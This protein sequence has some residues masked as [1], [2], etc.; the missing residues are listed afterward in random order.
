MTKKHSK[1]SSTAFKVYD[2]DAGLANQP[3]SP[4]Q[5]AQQGRQR[6]AVFAANARRREAGHNDRFYD[7]QEYERRV[8][9][10]RSRLLVST[11][12]AF[13]HIKRLHEEQGEIL[14]W[15]LETANHLDFVGTVFIFLIGGLSFVREEYKKTW[16]K[17]FVIY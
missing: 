3:Q 9:K 16:G 4:H 15:I 11:E 8:R 13:T 12:E 5:I 10:R 14:I 6:A 1:Q 7:E 17:L 2:I